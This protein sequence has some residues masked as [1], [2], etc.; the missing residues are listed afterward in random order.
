MTKL[1]VVALFFLMIVNWC[2]SVTQ[3]AVLI[4]TPTEKF[5]ELKFVNHL[6]F[7]I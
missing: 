4:A 3:L 2:F 5:S 7:Q 6:H 1:H